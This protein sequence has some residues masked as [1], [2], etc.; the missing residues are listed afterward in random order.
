MNTMYLFTHEWMHSHLFT[1]QLSALLVLS[2][3]TE[4]HRPWAV[5]VWLLDCNWTVL[6]LH[7]QRLFA[8]M[9]GGRLTTRHLRKE[10][11]TE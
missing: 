8:T 11:K 4:G 1:Y 7:D 3:L 6:A 9:S 5:A 2:D 10:S